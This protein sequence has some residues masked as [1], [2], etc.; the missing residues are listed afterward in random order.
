MKLLS[1]LTIYFCALK[2]AL[3]SVKFYTFHTGI[4]QLAII[5][6]QQ[7]CYAKYLE[8]CFCTV[9]FIGFVVDVL[10]IDHHIDAVVREL[11]EPSVERIVTAVWFG[12]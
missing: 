7:T 9:G 2:I 6:I 5:E 12:I 10:S 3:R 8:T 11:I 1:Y 4:Q